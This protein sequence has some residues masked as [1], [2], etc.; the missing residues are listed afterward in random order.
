M[1]TC[2]FLI[3]E[4]ASYR[5]RLS[6]H[7]LVKINAMC[8]WCIASITCMSWWVFVHFNYNRPFF[9]INQFHPVWSFRDIGFLELLDILCL[10]HIVYLWGRSFLDKD[11]VFNSKDCDYFT[12]LIFIVCKSFHSRLFFCAFP[13]NL[14]NPVS[15]I[16]NAVDL[17]GSTFDLFFISSLKATI[18]CFRILFLASMIFL[19]LEILSFNPLLVSVSV[20]FSFMT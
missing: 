13:Q 14:C 15:Q 19:S 1:L 5:A 8:E 17:V 18:A 2:E 3:T 16:L 10:A 20:N 6:L 11:A 12:E 9:F 7:A 4:G